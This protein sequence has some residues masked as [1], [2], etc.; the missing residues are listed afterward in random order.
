MAMKSPWSTETNVFLKPKNK[1]NLTVSFKTVYY[2]GGEKNA[3]DG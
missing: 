2:V 3:G 1:V